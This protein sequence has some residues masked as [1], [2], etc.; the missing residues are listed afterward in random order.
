M[1]TMPTS[2]TIVTMLDADHWDEAAAA[3][4]PSRPGALLWAWW[5][6]ASLALA[7]LAHRLS[8]LTTLPR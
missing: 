2:S 5:A 3:H 8:K 4:G 1:A 7:A 6:C